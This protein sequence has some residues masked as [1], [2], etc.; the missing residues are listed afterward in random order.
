MSQAPRPRSRSRRSPLP[1][2]KLP[3]KLPRLSPEAARIGRAVG[4]GGI[5]FGVLTI[6]LVLGF[7]LRLV[8]VGDVLN[9]F[10]EENVDLSE[11]PNATPNPDFQA[12]TLA[13][14]NSYQ[15]W[16][17]N[18]RVTILLMGADTRPIE[19][20]NGER[21]RS[22]TM[23]LVMVDPQQGVASMLSIPRDLFVDIPGYGLRRINTAYAIGGPPLA[24]ETVQ[25]N[26]GLRINY[27]IMI[28]FDVFTTVV[29]EIGGIDIYVPE[30]I[31]DPYYPDMTY[32]YDPFYI[33]AGFHHLDG[34][35]ALKYVRTRHADSD[36][37]RAR[38]QQDVMLAIRDR[39]LDL[40]MLPT[41]L[42]RAPSLYAQLQNS[43][44][45]DLSLDQMISLALLVQ[46]IPK[47]NIRTGVIGPNVV[48]DYVTP[49][50]SQVLI[51]LRS[52]IGPYMEEVFW[53]P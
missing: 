15:E 28:E 3:F 36:F 26:L 5:F 52:E 50:G 11:L 12:P 8:L 40:D 51:P 13:V 34:T 20:Q 19:R 16:Q 31:S 37:D 38:R 10:D 44:T 47:E 6:S 30:T 22:D 1:A 48:T 14:G 23:M 24:I 41:L 46:D 25:Y 49:D 43:I 21:P 2:L 35:T 29:D 27:Y 18:E 17:G 42:G 45:T 7:L 39:V 53:L 4:I 33:E 32:G 9:P